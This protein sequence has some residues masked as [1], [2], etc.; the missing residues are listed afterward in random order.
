MSQLE[1]AAVREL[2]GQAVQESGQD[3]L[4]YADLQV[5]LTSSKDFGPGSI[6]QLTV[7]PA[8]L[9]SHPAPC[10]YAMGEL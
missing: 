8:P 2:Q 1:E 6:R 3:A 4:D 5:L 10:D 9:L 7:R